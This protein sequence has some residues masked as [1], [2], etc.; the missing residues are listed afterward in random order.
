[1]TIKRYRQV[2]AR[3][4]L[5]TSLLLS[6]GATEA[7][8]Q[9]QFTR[10]TNGI[11]ANELLSGGQSSTRTLSQS[12]LFPTVSYSTLPKAVR[13]AGIDYARPRQS[14]SL[15]AVTEVSQKRAGASLSAAAPTAS[16]PVL[17]SDAIAQLNNQQLRDQLRIDS[18]ID[19][20]TD[21]ISRQA[22][23]T[24]ASSFLTP[25]AYGADWGDVYVGLAQ[26]TA[27]NRSTFDGSAAIG[28]GFGDAVKNVG[29][30][31]STS[32]ISL[33]G[34]GDD[35]IV[36]LKLHKIFPKAGNLAVALGWSNPIKWGDATKRENNFYG[37]ATKQF[38]LRPNHT[39]R[40]PLTASLGLGSADPYL[41][42]GE[43]K[44]SLGV[45]GSLGLRVIPEVSLITSWTGTYL[46]VAA[47][48][49]PFKAPF[50]FSVGASDI[51]GRSAEGTRFNSTVGYSFSF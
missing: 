4:A 33:N 42:S 43:G 12:R 51:T 6:V 24:P 31:V 47:S 44:N 10:Q 11:S 26:V 20:D 18:N 50:V 40:L 30:E 39:N 15:P 28:I 32:I 3:L 17:N 5:S 35:G 27:G 22:R 13:P 23:P 16:L 34:I 46:S 48:A 37:V 49:A 41:T 38:D 25:T 14:V 1:M 2:L 7:V 21:T 29:V 36:G 45:F 19:A 8:A 9:N